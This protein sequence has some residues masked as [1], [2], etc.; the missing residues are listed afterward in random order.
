MIKIIGMFL[1]G[2]GILNFAWFL[3]WALLAFSGSAG[4]RLS[5]KV[6]TANEGTDGAIHIADSYGKV[7]LTKVATSAVLAG[8]GCLCY[9]LIG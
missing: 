8:I 5:K 3:F 2:T 7:A 1:I 6:G 4:A 9:Y